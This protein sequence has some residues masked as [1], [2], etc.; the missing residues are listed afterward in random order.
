[1]WYGQNNTTIEE[2]LLAGMPLQHHPKSGTILLCDYSGFKVPEMVKTRP[3]V[4][5]SPRLRH[6]DRL[7]T[8]VPLSGTEPKHPEKYH[9]IL[10]FDRPLP[11]PWNSPRYWVKAD[12]LATVGFDRLNLI[13]LDVTRKASGNT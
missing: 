5:I 2:G 7:C 8:V 11:K 1:L 13:G 9:H 6:R 3:V 10:T 4:I 12:M